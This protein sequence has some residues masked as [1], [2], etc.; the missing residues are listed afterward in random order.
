MKNEKDV[1]LY[2]WEEAQVHYIHWQLKDYHYTAGI[3]RSF[4]LG[5]MQMHSPFLRIFYIDYR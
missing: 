1:F 3:R 2:I 4:L 5:G